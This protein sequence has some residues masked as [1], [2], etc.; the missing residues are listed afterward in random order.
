MKLNKLQKEVEKKIFDSL[1]RDTTIKFEAQKRP[2][3]ES[4]KKMLQNQKNQL[5]KELQKITNMLE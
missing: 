3:S 2:I 5:E 1:N 4:R